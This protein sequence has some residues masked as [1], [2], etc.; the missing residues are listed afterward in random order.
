MGRGI[1]LVLFYFPDHYAWHLYRGRPESVQRITNQVC[2]RRDDDILMSTAGPGSTTS[3][4]QAV[5][6]SMEANGMKCHTDK[7]R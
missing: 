7:K 4:A 3:F 2:F 5:E 1:L 6:E